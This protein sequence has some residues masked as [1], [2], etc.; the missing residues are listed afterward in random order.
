MSIL[1]KI[2]VKF[3]NI[4]YYKGLKN[5]NIFIDNFAIVNKK[6]NFEGYNKVIGKTVV[7]DSNIGLGTYIQAR[8][9]IQKCKIG[10]WCSIAPDVKII[11]G[12]HPSKDYV[13][14]HPQFYSKRFNNNLKI[15][16]NNEFEEFSYTDESRKWYCEIGNDVWIGE[17]VSILNGIKIGNGAIIAAGAIVTKDVPDYAIVGGIPAKII[18]FRFSQDQIEKLK[19]IKWWEKDLDWIKENVNSFNN[20]EKFLEEVNVNGNV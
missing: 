8:S 18:K 14:T 7:L 17:R 2:G 10:R 4:L 20:I 9:D 1:R 16:S 11:I 12:N 3:S 6:T 19:R 13:S 15:E 5:K